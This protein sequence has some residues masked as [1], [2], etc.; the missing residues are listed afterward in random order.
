M[1]ILEKLK[2]N[3]QSSKEG[4]FEEF[5]RIGKYLMNEL[6]LE[7]NQSKFRIVECEFYLF[8]E[9]GNHKDPYTHKRDEQAQFGKWYFN[10][11]GIDMP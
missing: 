1:S 9:N 4:Y 10:D 11:F 5:K 8:E 6:H 3:T 2:V 7:V